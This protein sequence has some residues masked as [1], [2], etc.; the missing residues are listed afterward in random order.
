M[1]YFPCLDVTG[2]IPFAIG[3]NVNIRFL[4]HN[5]VPHRK[6][7]P[8]D[9]SMVYLPC[10]DLTG[11]IPFASGATIHIPFRNDLSIPHLETVTTCTPVIYLARA[12][13]APH[14][15]LA[16]G[17]NILETLAFPRH[18]PRTALALLRAAHFCLPVSSSFKNRERAV[19]NIE[20]LGKP[21]SNS[22]FSAPNSQF[23]FCISVVGALEK[24][25]AAPGRQ[26]ILY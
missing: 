21:S 17:T 13:T 24:G 11:H 14:G 4:L 10:L 23:S 2:H 18:L 12:Y 3:A 26:P 6:L 9:C 25:S 16:S 7:V 22:H 8:A 20:I 19:G 5:A 15:L 1:I